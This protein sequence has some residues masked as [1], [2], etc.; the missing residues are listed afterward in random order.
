MYSIPANATRIRYLESTGTQYVDTLT[1][2]DSSLR[3]VM[4]YACYN[5]LVRPFGAADVRETTKNQWYLVNERNQAVSN[6]SLGSTTNATINIGQSPVGVR[7]TATIDGRTLSAYGKTTSMSSWTLT[8][9]TDD[10]TL[11]IFACHVVR[12]DGSNPW[13]LP[14]SMRLFSCAIYDGSTLVRSFVP[15]RV[16]STG[17]MFDR[18]T[19]Q[20]FYNQG[21]GS[22]VCGEDD[23]SIFSHAVKHLSDTGTFLASRA[24]GNDPVPPY[25]AQVE[26]I[27][28]SGTQWIDTGI[29]MKYGDDFSFDFE[30]TNLDS[31]TSYPG[32]YVM[33][34]L[35]SGT[36]SRAYALGWYTQNS[37]YKFLFCFQYDSS[38]YL[39]FP[40]PVSG[41][42]YK[43]DCHVEQNNMRM[44]VD[45]VTYT[46]AVNSTEQS[47]QLAM[48]ARATAVSNGKITTV[49]ALS[50]LKIYSAR[51]YRNGVLVRDYTPVRVGT[52]YCMYDQANPH[53]GDNGDG[54]YH[55]K[56]SGSFTGGSDTAVPSAAWSVLFKTVRRHYDIATSYIIDENNGTSNTTVSVNFPSDTYSDL[57]YTPTKTGYSF[58]GWD[59]VPTS[60]IVGIEYL[61]TSGTQYINTGVKAALNT[62]FEII[63]QNTATTTENYFVIGGRQAMSSNE[64]CLRYHSNNGVMDRVYIVLNSTST[65]LWND[66]SVSQNHIAK[67]SKTGTTIVCGSQTKNPTISDFSTD[68][69]MLLF[70]ML[71]ANGS[72]QVAP[73]LRIYR[74]K[75]YSGS[76]LVRDFMPVRV[77][78]E[79]GMYDAVTKTVF[80]NA[81]T[82]DFIKG[83]DSDISPFDAIDS[84]DHVDY[85]LEKVTARYVAPLSVTF[86]ATTNGGTMPSG[87]VSPTY[88]AGYT[89]GTLPLPTKSGCACIGWFTPFGARVE[90][91]TVV[92]YENSHLIAKYEEVTWATTYSVTTTSSYKKTGI[93]SATRSG[94]G[95]STSNPIIV[96]WGDG[97]QD[98]VFGN[99]SSLTHTYASATTYTVKIS[100]NISTF[101]PS[102]NNSTWSATTSQ[103]RYTFKKVLTLS[104]KVTQLSS[105]AFY[106]C[107]AMTDVI[108]PSGA[109]SI[110]AYCFYYCSNLKSSTAQL[111]S[112]VTS[113]G[114]NAFY[115]CTG[116]NF[117][118]ITIPAACTS[119][120][121][122]AFY[123]CYY[124]HPVFESGSSTLSLNQYSF[125]YCG[126]NGSAF[127][128]D[129][130]QR[131]VTSIPN[132]C[133][134]YCRYLKAFTFPQGVTSIGTNAFSYCFNQSSSTGTLEIPEGVTSISGTYAFRDCTYLTAIT[135]PSTI[136]N[137]N[138]YTFYNCTRLA[139]I[140]C[141][142]ATAPTVSAATFGNGTSNYTGRSSYSAGTNRLHVPVNA[143]G[144][145]SSYWLDPLCSSTK[146]GFT[147]QYGIN[148]PSIDDLD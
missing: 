110:P 79:G 35:L 91:S 30:I 38:S 17:C 78:T 127:T 37:V 101:R 14:A 105:Y 122:S 58:S 42:R 46:S 124:L 32:G 100:D 24:I 107:S 83:A 57:D 106:Y 66:T 93:Y 112:T 133:F 115:A 69:D 137:L 147:I 148:E 141:T 56:G 76:T 81:G 94:G 61:E 70:G 22:F 6:C 45:G 92:S 16:G 134:N 68:V 97:T 96:D 139:T 125:G 73:G 33:A 67:V 21:T 10:C 75:I 129:M 113:I 86:D 51:H 98:A 63:F 50:K 19:G 15:V 62:N 104:S 146:C 5:T 39:S 29:D 26:Y 8:P 7:T 126:Y 89:F 44:T 12:T 102:A 140:T 143:T 132:Y 18:V 23:F 119:I 85:A 59:K 55:N 20:F 27:Q 54:L 103:N 64:C 111:P 136:T 80:R 13:V 74:A 108:I 43:V 135:L 2:M 131:K 120:G 144:Y 128:I 28:S 117:S 65:E 4:D 71:Q 99:I 41:R 47:S 82:G 95:G 34:S 118:S 3:V 40:T 116:S 145:E 53:G 60:E 77:G 121:S 31:S 88:H 109:T 36:E 72:I 11:G 114:S 90:A 48:F 87:W 52:E 130:S 123:C 142:R 25:D 9:R 1:P 138:N 84:G 49:N